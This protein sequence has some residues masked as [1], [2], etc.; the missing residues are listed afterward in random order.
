MDP[1]DSKNKEET[2]GIVGVESVRIT[3]ELMS[4]KREASRV[5]GGRGVHTEDII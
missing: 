2:R 1:R 3:D 4:K 5:T